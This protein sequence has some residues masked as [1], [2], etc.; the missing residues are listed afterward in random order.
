MIKTV[1]TKGMHCTS[2][3]KIIEKAALSVK[4]VNAAKSNFANEQTTI[5][6]DETQTDLN[7]I[8]QVIS[9]KGYGCELIQ[10]KEPTDEEYY[11]LPKLNSKYLLI[12]GFF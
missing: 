9:K 2:C 1:K 6:F 8:L 5:D 11:N 10:P 7:I 4:G 12:G 3:E